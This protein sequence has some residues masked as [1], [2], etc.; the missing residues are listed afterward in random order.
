MYFFPISTD[1]C[2]SHE[3]KHGE[4]SDAGCNGYLRIQLFKTELSGGFSWNPFSMLYLESFQTPPAILQQT[5]VSGGQELWTRFWSEMLSASRHYQWIYRVFY[6]TLYAWFVLVV[7]QSAPWCPAEVHMVLTFV[8]LI[9]MIYSSRRLLPAIHSRAQLVER[10]ADEF[11]HCGFHV[12]YRRSYEF[13][14]RSNMSAVHYLYVF[15]L[16]V[17]AVHHEGSELV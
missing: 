12:E 2:K 15:P 5:A 10:Y 14:E 1:H 13:D 9:P 16:A 8:L 3:T 11:A 4:D 17:S 6:P 7:L